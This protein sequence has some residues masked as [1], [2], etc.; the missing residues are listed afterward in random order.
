MLALIFWICRL[1]AERPSNTRRLLSEWKHSLRQSWRV[2]LSIARMPGRTAAMLIRIR[3][4]KNS[5]N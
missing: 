2:K 5:Q 1:I 3:S 4:G